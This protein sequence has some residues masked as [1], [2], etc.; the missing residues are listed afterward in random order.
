[1][2]LAKSLRVAMALKNVRPADVAEALEIASPHVYAWLKTGGM[3]Q[4]NMLRLAHY[5]GMAM[6]EFI[7]LGEDN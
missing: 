4:K 3:T 5:F 6:S 1:M 7:K 2:D